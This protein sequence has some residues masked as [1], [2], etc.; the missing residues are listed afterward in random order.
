MKKIFILTISA[1]LLWPASPSQAC[2]MCGCSAGG[3]FFGMLP[4]L[5]GRYASLRTQQQWFRHPQTSLN[6]IDGQALTYDRMQSVELW[7][8]WQEGER[9]QYFLQL[10]YRF[11]DR[12]STNGVMSSI[13]GMGD[14][15][16]TT[17][18]KWL[19]PKSM[20]DWQHSSSIGLQLGA[21]TG[22]F[23][24]RDQQMRMLPEAFQTGTGSWSLQPQLF[25]TLSKGNS[26]LQLEARRRG[27]T[28]NELDFKMGTQWGGSLQYFLNRQGKRVRWM[29]YGGVTA[30]YAEAETL[31]GQKNSATGG[32]IY[33][34][35]GG[36]DVYTGKSALH[37][38]AQLPVYQVIGTGQP[39]STF[40]WMIGYSRTF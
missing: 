30:D 32:Q 9:W 27:F 38:L 6:Q 24:Q 19:K 5:Q 22:L 34:F 28:T 13:A 21:P 25:Y 7:L 31:Y 26:G 35:S 20:G 4:L 3:Q 39:A 40:R 16:F 14:V 37:L 23:Q 10:P 18:Y 17:F 15:Q 2:D 33:G 12:M 8:R 29:H 11:H 36:T 1:L